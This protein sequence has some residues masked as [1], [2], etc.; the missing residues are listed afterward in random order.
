VAGAGT[1]GFATGGVAGTVGLGADG[2][3]LAAVGIG[4]FA[5]A[6]GF[7]AGSGAV[8]LRPRYS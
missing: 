2:T 5:G 6:V 1:A 3:G 8:Y 7:G 4:G